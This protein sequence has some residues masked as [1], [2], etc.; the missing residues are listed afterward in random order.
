MN[1]R[2]LAG[3]A[4]VL[5]IA[6]GG[7][8]AAHAQT[9]PI[10]RETESPAAQFERRIAVRATN[11]LA[12]L[13]LAEPAVAGKVREA[14]LRFYRELQSAHA[15][16]DAALARLPGGDAPKIH[17]AL[18][19]A[20]KQAHEVQGRFVGT[21]TPILDAMQIEAV[22]DWMTFEMLPLSIAEYQRMFPTM[23]AW[24]K[25]QIRVWLVEAREASVIAGSS[26]TKLDVFR[27]NK[28]R[29]H[30]Y[31]AAQGFDVDTALKAE[32]ARKAAEKKP[33]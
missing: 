9:T 6:L 24:Q 7:T 22:K 15:A 14:V 18:F 13:K 28:V 8:T 20:D 16:R 10:I 25:K 30:A 23:T 11:L 2:N 21:L 19:E 33:E 29:M 4:L 1:H 3:L 17:H 26:E 27:V 31:L 32:A 5:L 12:H